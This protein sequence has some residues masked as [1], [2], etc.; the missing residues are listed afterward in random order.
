MK[1]FPL[2]SSKNSV[3]SSNQSRTC[4]SCVSSQSVSNFI[5]C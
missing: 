2:V 5:W 4:V 1:D 3:L